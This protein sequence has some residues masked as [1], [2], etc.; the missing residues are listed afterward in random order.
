[1][2]PVI[3]QIG[4]H[5]VLT[6]KN[7]LKQVQQLMD[8]ANSYKNI[9]FRYHA[10]DMQLH[11]DIDTAF[12]VSPKARSRIA[13]YFRLLHHRSSS[14]AHYKDNGPLLVECKTLRSVVTSA[15]EAETHGVF[16]NAKVAIPIITT[17]NL[18]GHT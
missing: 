10:S 2:L 1:M 4:I 8:Y 6:T 18:M 3:N 15:A 11:V 9:H 17:L 16:H 14:Y 13:G 12:L 5:Q 7:T